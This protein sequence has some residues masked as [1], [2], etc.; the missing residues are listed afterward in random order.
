VVKIDKREAF[1]TLDNLKYLIIIT[2]TFVS[3]VI[4]IASLVIGKSISKPII[5]LRNLAKE[6]ANGNPDVSLKE[7]GNLYPYEN[8]GKSKN[9]E[10]KDLAV[11]FDKMRQKIN[12]TNA[13]L[14]ELIHQK[15]K[16][17]EKA[18]EDLREKERH[19]TEANEKLR[20]LDKLKNDFINIAAHELR[21]PTQA[22]LSF[23]DLLMIYP[24][25]KVVTETIQRNARRLKRL[26]SDILDVTK[27]ENQRLVLKKEATNIT[28]LV[29]SIVDEYKEHI[30]K[31]SSTKKIELYLDTPK[32]R[33]IIVYADRERMVQ[34]ISNLLDNSVKFIEKE[35][36][37][38][39]MVKI[40]RDGDNMKEMNVE[41]NHRD[42]VVISIKDT[43][44]SIP[45]EIFPILFTKFTAKS[46]TGAGLG[47]YISKSIIE[48]HGGR[49]WA[50]NN[51][52]GKG[53]TFTLSLPLSKKEINNNYSEVSRNGR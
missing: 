7:V 53:V 16:D 19:L 15:T 2:G 21:T 33:E 49:I 34:V 44:V 47:L 36:S 32:E 12:Y 18:I 50:E 8:K 22:I 17:L 3:I 40:K 14:Q 35:G 38:Y 24:D 4:I 1:A 23:S 11:Q 39:L 42:Q 31:T 26:I 37:I 28:S 51:N 13:N 48:A 5:K 20:L 46:I 27:I 25:K 52:D 43:G 9:D 45:E 29:F 41:D 6:M 30:K 10:I